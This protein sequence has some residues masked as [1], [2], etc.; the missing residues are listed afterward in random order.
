MK[1]KKPKAPKVS[2]KAPKAPKP[3][4]PKVPSKGKVTPQMFKKGG[5]VKDHC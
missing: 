3:S 5:K 4:M 2:L 1:L